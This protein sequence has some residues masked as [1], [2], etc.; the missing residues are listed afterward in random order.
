[1]NKTLGESS[2]FVSRRTGVEEAALKGEV[3]DLRRQLEATN[4]RLND[5]S[6]KNT[7]LES[8]IQTTVSESDIPR[9]RESQSSFSL[10]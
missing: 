9:F 6:H 3:V 4:K 8:L 5:L 10:A 2:N 1:M 7:L